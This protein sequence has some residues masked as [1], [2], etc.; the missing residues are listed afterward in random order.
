VIF[1]HDD[2]GRHILESRIVKRNAKAAH[3]NA[4][5]KANYKATVDLPSVITLFY[6]LVNG[7]I[8]QHT[9]LFKIMQNQK[10][11]FREP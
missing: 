7:S 11:L 8:K 2:E 3:L 10:L 6:A 4:N 1:A 9:R 5:A